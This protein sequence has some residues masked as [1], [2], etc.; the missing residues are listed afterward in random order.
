MEYGWSGSGTYLTAP[1]VV[2]TTEMAGLPPS[3]G[4]VLA[5]SAAFAN[6]RGAVWA[7]VEFIAG[8]SCSPPA[9][10]FV[11]VWVLRSLDGGLTFED[12]SSTAA[13][14]RA[15]DITIPIP[16]GTSI[17]PHAGM[18][19]LMLPPGTFKVALRNQMGITVPT[20]STLRIAIY[21]EGSVDDTSGPVMNGDANGTQAYRIADML[22]R[23]GVVTY[24]QSSITVNPWGAGTSDY[25]TASVIQ[26]LTWLTANSGMICNIREYHVAGADTDLGSGQLTWCPTVAAALGAKFSVS[27]LRGAGTS[28][29]ATL[30][31]MA[32]SSANG[33]GWLSWAEGLNTPNDGSV[34]AANCITVQQAI[35]TGCTATQSLT[36]PVT[37]VG[38][39]F[40]YA[41]LPPEGAS[42]I[43]GYLTAGQ[44][45]ALLASTTL[46]S[47]R[48]FPALN[49]GYDDSAGRGGNSDD[50]AVGLSNYYGKPLI[51]GEWHPTSGNTD[52][53]SHAIDDS[54]GAFYAALMMLHAHRLGFVA[55]FWKSLFD[56]G[57]SGESPWTRVGLFPNAGS[58][59]PRLPARTI[60]AMYAL[61][62]DTGAS[63]RSFTT[64]RLDYS[65]S[66]LPAAGSNATPWTGGHHRLFQNSGGT[67]YLFVWNEQRPILGSATTVTIAFARSMARVVHYD[68][69]TDPTTAETPVTTQTNITSLTF[70]LTASV[71]LFVISPL[72]SIVPTESAQDTTL[73]S[74]AGAIYDAAGVS[75]TLVSNPPFGL[76]V[77]HAGQT[78]LSNVITLFYHDHLVW[79]QNASGVFQYWN[80]MSWI[81]GN[82]PRIVAGES[83]DGL[84][85]SSPGPIIYASQI[86]GQTAGATLDQWTLTID[87]K[88]ARNGST[89]AVD[90]TANVRQVVYHNHYVYHVNFSDQWYYWT[91]VWN[92]TTAPFGATESAEG[93]I[94][95]TVGPVIYASTSP[96]QP[97]FGTL[98]KFEINVS[99]QVVRN[100]IADTGTS[101]LLELLYHNHIVYQEASNPSIYG[102]PG[103]WSWSGTGWVD[104]PSPL[105]PTESTDGTDI[106]VAGTI[107]YASQTPGQPAGATLDQWTFTGGQVTKNGS[108]SGAGFSSGVNRMYYAGH[109]VY[110]SSPTQNSLGYT[111][112]W[113]Q[114]NGTTWVDCAPPQP[115]TK[116]ISISTIPQQT[117]GQ[118]FTVTGTLGAYVTAPSLQYRDNAGAYVAF[119]GG[120]L[121]TA[122]A[123]SFVHPSIGSASASFTVGVRDAGATAITVTSNTFAVVAAG[124]VT[125]TGM[126]LSGT[127]ILAG[128]SAGTPIGTI[129]VQATG[130][131]FSGSLAVDDVARFQIGALSALQNKIPLSQGSY[132]I[133][134]T[135]TMSG[136]TGSPFVRPFTI[137]AAASGNT[138]VNLSDP[139]GQVMS[140][141]IWGFS[142]GALGDVFPQPGGPPSTHFDV[143]ARTTE[144]NT[145]AQIRPTLLRV[146][147]DQGLYQEYSANGQTSNMNN[148]WNNHTKFMDP[149]YRF[150]VGIGWPWP[151]AS[152]SQAASWAFTFANGQKQAGHEIFYWEVGN[153]P[154]GGQS[155][156]TY[157][158][159]FNAIA[160][161][162]HLVNPAYKVG[163][164][165]TS[166]FSQYN[167]LQWI[168]GGAN[169][170]VNGA[171]RLG[172]YVAHSYNVD[173]SE[174]TLADK[175]AKANGIDT[176]VRDLLD[177]NG[178]AG[179]P[180]YMNEYNMD[181]TPGRETLQ[182][183][184]VGAIY[185]ALELHN[186][187]AILGSR[188][189]GAG[190]WDIIYDQNYGAVA[191]RDVSPGGNPSTIDPQGYYLGKAGQTLF[192]T[193]YR[194]STTIANMKI[195]AVKPTT[196]T[197]AIQLIN[198]DTSSNKTV[199]LSLLG[200]TPSGT[201]T[202]WEIG[203][204]SPN[205]PTISTQPS[206]AT[207]S[208]ASETIVILSGQV[209]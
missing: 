177:A 179:C 77:N 200:G 8:A 76:Q 137:A 58:D 61:T 54:F 78:D 38:P 55:W 116:T 182:G 152:A 6:S 98:D 16:S 9:D 103:W 68:L 181:G 57:R 183:T 91:T 185:I 66:G 43:T 173:Q 60:R 62:G 166:Y 30:V 118:S 79:A 163:G 124:S 29:A 24:S 107:I 193:E 128:A 97:A 83:A 2:L 164:P 135:A 65:I 201:I 32:T 132:P 14:A 127:S 93:T 159:Y 81:T 59:T 37:A 88:V 25:T 167:D 176:T 158:S 31:G 19:G 145:M 13:P 117:V 69:T 129:A 4:D 204:S 20:G 82:D 155:V 45:T 42:A 125:L 15:A 64:S 206:L 112:G 90:F 120:A 131:S 110:Q 144:Q 5:V 197:F 136:A 63:K 154:A 119:P 151:G 56:I 44:K 18:P 168:N 48:Y 23:F 172:F 121:V 28:D 86:P 106:T 160:D 74:P 40:T 157:S 189:E 194:T 35:Y 99:A 123:F 178:L 12:G 39:S 190:L 192:G 80:G 175:Y 199:S 70:S 33:T 113:W 96:G 141:Y 187:F 109:F 7:D 134:L 156:S 161:Q 111:P 51:V 180:I 11:E 50:V 92:A 139:T 49:P 21:G 153:E 101:A 102:A 191:N 203:K 46:A 126:T 146:N 198:Y 17:T 89:A 186:S 202:R 133:N 84:T 71:H 114:W 162:L 105:T 95:N 147:A 165:N 140:K 115:A 85:I 94:V 130:G 1:I 184:Y 138:T 205:T 10:S 72:G 149:A 170:V 148:W 27:L 36:Y 196:T 142:T 209:S 53:P 108:T 150:V 100:D 87:A 169:Q 34:T 171:K 207:I 41:T 104:T 22:E 174:P 73:S 67:F 3:A 208:V 52:S 26:A 75:Y 122:T 195:L 188:F 143:A 47:I